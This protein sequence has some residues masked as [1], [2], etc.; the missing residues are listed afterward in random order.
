VEF[1]R[2]LKYLVRIKICFATLGHGVARL[3][4]RQ[5]L[6]H[7]FPGV[8]GPAHRGSMDLALRLLLQQLHR[9]IPDVCDGL[10]VKWMRDSIFIKL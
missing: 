1:S 3:K 8:Q 7:L 4:K 9:K 10:S 5:G 2:V 6:R